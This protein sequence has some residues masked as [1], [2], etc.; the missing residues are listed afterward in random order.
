VMSR[1]AVMGDPC[2]VLNVPAG[3]YLTRAQWQRLR[4]VAVRRF[5]LPNW[6]EN[7]ASAQP[8]GL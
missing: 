1:M 8:F 7:L 3:S 5:S 4:R 2:G 6:R